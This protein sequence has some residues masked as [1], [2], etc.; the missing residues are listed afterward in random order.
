MRSASWRNV[1]GTSNCAAAPRP[2]VIPGITEQATPACRNAS[3]SSPPRPKIKGS[4][5]FSRTAGFRCLDQQAIDGALADAR[6][7]DATANR[8]A[9]CVTTRAVE[10]FRRYQFVVENDV[11]VLQCAQGLDRQQIRIARPR[12]NQRYAALGHSRWQRAGKF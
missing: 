1:S 11:G 6:L 9:G 7:A 10:N 3:I 5:P 8:D 4:P 2:A 12:A